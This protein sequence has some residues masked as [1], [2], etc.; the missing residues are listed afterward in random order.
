MS[1]FPEL[2]K[3]E[4]DVLILVAQ[5]YRD[6]DI[7]DRLSISVCTVHNHVRHIIRRLEV[8]NR[9]AATRLYWQRNAAKK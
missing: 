2:T 9:T 4:C 6:R 1:Q 5:G 7:A 8:P 3:R